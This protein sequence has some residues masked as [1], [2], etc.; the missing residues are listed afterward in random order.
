MNELLDIQ[1]QLISVVAPSGHEKSRGRIIAE[2]VRPFVDEVFSDVM[3]NLYAHKR[4]NGSK[5]MVA[6]H[7]DTL[8]FVVESIDQKGFVKVIALG[9]MPVYTLI[10]KRI[11]FEGGA[12]GTIL[13]EPRAE[14][15]KK[16]LRSIMMNQLFVDIGARD[17]AEAKSL[18]SLRE[19]AVYD[20]P[21]T[22]LNHTVLLSSYCDD[23]MGC[24]VVIDAIRKTGE[25]LNYMYYVFTVQEEVGCRGAQPAANRFHPDVGV[26]VEVTGALDVMTRRRDE[27]SPLM[28]GGPTLD[29]YDSC[30]IFDAGL[31][32]QICEMGRRMGHPCQIKCM[33]TGGTDASAIQGVGERARLDCICMPT[34]YIHSQAEM[35]DLRDALGVRDILL[36]LATE[37][38]TKDGQ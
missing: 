9:G 15:A 18:V 22:I 29:A 13:A 19:F 7:M 34:R 25:P 11:R 32:D 35:L 17:R 27:L 16:D 5:I 6:A 38:F 20:I 28:G 36:A 26:I 10:G 3:G 8:G 21:P 30:T 37:S 24:S 33:S 4:G 1:K 12:V 31:I 14:V 2:L 23:L